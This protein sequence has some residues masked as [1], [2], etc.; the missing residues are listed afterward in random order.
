MNFIKS[1]NIYVTYVSR[2]S[3]IE[4]RLMTITQF[5]NHLYD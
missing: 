4:F 1:A 2:I 3:E 5:C